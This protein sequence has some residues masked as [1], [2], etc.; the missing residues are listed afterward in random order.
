MAFR[1]DGNG[2]VMEGAKFPP[3]PLP[4]NVTEDARQAGAAWAREVR[5][6]G[7]ESL[8]AVVQSL[9]KRLDSAVMQDVGQ[10]VPRQEIL[11]LDPDPDARYSVSLRAERLGHGVV[12]VGE[13]A[14]VPADYRPT[15]I[16][17][18]TRLPDADDAVE[19]LR[20]RFDVPIIVCTADARDEAYTAARRAG[21]D[22]VL[23][24]PVPIGRLLRAMTSGVRV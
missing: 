12:A 18:E 6:S 14:A 2:F 20:A 22:E 15:V 21:A 23:V 9:V 17:T 5:D 8:H 3:L 11:L 7:S 4:A 1:A 19:K 16:V 10:D 13:L 24:K